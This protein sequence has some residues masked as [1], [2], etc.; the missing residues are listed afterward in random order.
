MC[1]SGCVPAAAAADDHD[2]DHHDDN[3]DDDEDEVD[4]NVEARGPLLKLTLS[5]VSCHTQ[6]PHPAGEGE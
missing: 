6:P 1:V 2:N 5:S 3:D 4:D